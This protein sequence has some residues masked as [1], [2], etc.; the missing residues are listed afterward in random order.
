MADD[1]TKD[2]FLEYLQKTIASKENVNK[3]LEKMAGLALN[4]GDR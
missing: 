3:Y 4:A 2:Y 1:K